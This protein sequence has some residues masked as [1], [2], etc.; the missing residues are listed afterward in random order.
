MNVCGNGHMLP[1]WS[2]VAEMVTCCRN[3]HML[4]KWSH[5]AEMVTCCRNGHMLPKWSHVAEMATCCHWENIKGLVGIF[6]GS[7]AFLC[8]VVFW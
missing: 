8:V 6:Q 4:P 3:G 1:K 5:V 7:L 2:H